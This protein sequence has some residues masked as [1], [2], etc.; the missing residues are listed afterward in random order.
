[1]KDY[2]RR[3]LTRRGLLGKQGISAD[4]F[5]AGLQA[6]ISYMSRTY[7]QL[8][9]EKHTFQWKP[10][11]WDRKLYRDCTGRSRQGKKQS[12]LQQKRGAC[13]WTQFRAQE[14]SASEEAPLPITHFIHWVRGHPLGSCGP[15]L[16]QSIQEDAGARRPVGAHVAPGL[17]APAG[18]DGRWPHCQHRAARAVWRLLVSIPLGGCRAVETWVVSEVCLQLKCMWAG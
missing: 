4:S 3:R 13:H 11:T 18:G 9:A 15:L 14:L 10:P 17:H 8:G 5:G 2:E 6:E 1:M 7:S 16:I 12:G